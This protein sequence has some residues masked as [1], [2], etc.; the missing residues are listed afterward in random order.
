MSGTT[1]P[2]A[3]DGS[4]S[5]SL[6]K[7]EVLSRL[8]T[9]GMAEIFLA[10]QRGLAGFRKL[11]VLK[12]ILPDIRGEE[13]FIRMFLDEAKVTAAFNH[14]HIAQVF[15]LDIAEGELFLAMEFVPG[16]TLVEVAKACRQANH[17]IPMGFSLMSVRDT[18]VALHYAH[19]FTDPLGRPSPVIHRDVAEKNIMVTYEGVT[20]L[21]DFGIAKN[22]ARASRTAVGMVKGTSGYMSPEQIMG[23]PLDARSDL[24]SLGV[25]LHE[26]LTGMRLFYAKQ[27]EAM[28]NAVLRCEVTPPSRT[29]KQIPPELDAIVLRALSKRREDRYSSTLEFARA[30]ERAVGPLIWHPEQSSEVMS[31]LFAD[32]R[33]QTRQLLMAGPANGDA[34]SETSVAA[35]LANGG[36]PAPTPPEAPEPPT[37]N[38]NTGPP[39]T[40]R[41]SMT[42]V[43]TVKQSGTTPPA[44]PPPPPRRATTTAQ[45][46]TTPPPPPP[47][48]PEPRKPVLREPPQKRLASRGPSEPLR[49]PPAKETPPL[50]PDAAAMARTQPGRPALSSPS[51]PT[52]TPPPPP[53][54]QVSRTSD[55]EEAA[56]R[57]RSGRSGDALRAVPPSP[58]PPERK[59]EVSVARAPALSAEPGGHAG[60]PARR[61]N[62][63]PPARR[64]PQA[65]LAASFPPQAEAEMGVT[66]RPARA[67]QDARRASSEEE[68]H[69]D[70]DSHVH[71]QRGVPAVGASRGWLKLVAVVLVLVVVGAAVVGLGLDGGKVSSWL[72]PSAE[73]VGEPSKVRPLPTPQPIP[74]KADARTSPPTQPQAEVAQGVEVQKEPPADEPAPENKAAEDSK[75]LAAD[76]PEDKKR[77]PPRRPQTGRSRTKEATARTPRSPPPKT[78]SADEPQESAPTGGAPGFLSLSTDPYARVFLGGQLLGVTPLFKVSVPSGKQ[79]LKIVG[80]DG[81]ALKLPVDIKPGET[82]AVNVPLELLSQQ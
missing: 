42:A 81:K 38:T 55:A 28:M 23:E 79:V 9:G 2:L 75:S 76:E 33:E 30:L 5:R 53:S 26:L 59:P 40:R 51:A 54:A 65:Q 80:E 66:T 63:S 72:S 50:S 61:S 3:T 32:R 12:Q 44:T 20:K 10:S 43:P 82:R 27:A 62:A 29:N 52:R 19:T 74:P 22:L 18:A 78:D 49:L 25:V 15:D 6:G 45:P 34:T 71:T 37:V 57:S 24:F 41:P 60:V 46:A 48:D 4:K 47:P 73:P 36:L 7:Y 14:P 70:E 8:S 17:P 68:E 64:R 58:P 13:E 1:L 67:F 31:R 56:G 21:L 69:E 77:A 35:M 39:E 11:V 16:A